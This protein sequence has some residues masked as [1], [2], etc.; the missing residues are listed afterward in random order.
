MLDFVLSEPRGGVGVE[1]LNE[2]VLLY[3][4]VPIPIDFFEDLHEVVFISVGVEL[5][6]D[7]CVDHSF[8]L[9][10]EVE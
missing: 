5:G 4:S 8:Q 6:S 9:V 1:N 10:F 3:D 7:V 2:L